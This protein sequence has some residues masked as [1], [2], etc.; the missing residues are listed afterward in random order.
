MAHPSHSSKC[1]TPFYRNGMLERNIPVPCGKCPE[2]RARRVSG[3][4]FRLCKEAEVSSS[5]YFITLTYDTS[6]V[7][8]TSK[9]FM[10][11]WKPDFQKFIKRLRKRN[12]QALKYYAVGE[13]G[14]RSWRPHYH[15]IVFNMELETF[16]GKVLADHIRSGRYV[17]DGKMRFQALDWKL[18]HA[19]IGLCNAA[20]VGYCLEYM[21]KRRRIPVHEN[22]DRTPE[23]GLMSKGI[24]L[25]YVNDRDKRQW[26]YNDLDKRMY[27][28]V[29]GGK[30]IAMPRYYKDKI[31]RCGEC[32][33][34]L[35]GESCV[36]RKRVGFFARLDCIEEEVDSALKV[37]QDL[38][39]FRV[40]NSRSSKKFIL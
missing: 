38:A 34:C 20:S 9:G 22:D 14:E 27:C 12:S 1:R 33:G 18:G 13:Y 37:Q 23:F 19:T 11:L 30:K 25:C 36:R 7:P 6:F 4:S 21:S 28:N 15:A 8:I 2:C 10:A 39:A 24:G 40:E 5:A 35:S 26:H 31:Y 29:E 17:P 3:W 32:D 16:T